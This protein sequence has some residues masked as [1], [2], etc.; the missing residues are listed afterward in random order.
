[1]KIG[2]PAENGSKTIDVFACN[3]ATTPVA[4]W[5]Q[6]LADSTGFSVRTA[7]PGITMQFQSRFGTPTAVDRRKT[8][9]RE[10]ISDR[11]GDDDSQW[12]KWK[13]GGN[14]NPEKSFAHSQYPPFDSK[15]IPSNNINWMLEGANTYP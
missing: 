10:Q 9:L 2:H 3:E 8:G 15:G 5:G 13:P 14:G 1:M 11:K 12:V 4:K 6:Q 7:A